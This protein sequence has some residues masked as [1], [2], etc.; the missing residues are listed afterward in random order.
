MNAA[1]FQARHPGLVWSHSHASEFVLIRAALLKPRFHTILDACI[2]FGLDRVCGE[3][4][5]L[6]RDAAP[7]AERVRGEVTR[8]LQHIREGFADA[9]T[10]Q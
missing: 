10:G 8:I 2:E 7:E 1:T 6:L 4:E 5:V 3:W 9:Q